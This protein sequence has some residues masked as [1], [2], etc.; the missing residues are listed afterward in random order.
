LADHDGY[1]V[2]YWGQPL[3]PLVPDHTLHLQDVIDTLGDQSQRLRQ[4]LRL[5]ARAQELLRRIPDGVRDLG[6]F[7]LLVDVAAPS[8]T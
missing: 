2:L 7:R 6:R 5:R 1:C 8:S 3:R 4:E